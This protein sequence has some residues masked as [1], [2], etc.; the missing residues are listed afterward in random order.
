VDTGDPE[1]DEALAGETRVV[2]GYGRE[3]V[4]AVEG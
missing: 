3:S 4:Y 2:T 1:L